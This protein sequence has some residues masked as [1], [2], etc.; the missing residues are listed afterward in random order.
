MTFS[1]DANLVFLGD[2]YTTDLVDARHSIGQWPFIFNLEAPIS[3]RGRPAPG[4]V[5]L[6]MEVDYILDCF[7]RRPLAVCLANNHIMDYGAEAFEDTLGLLSGRGIPFFGAGH[8]QDNFNNPAFVEVGDQ[9]VAL[10]GYVCPSTHPIYADQTHPGVCPI[11][12]DHIRNDMRKAKTE[13]ATRI[14]V[15]LHWGA[16]EV[17]L[18]KPEDVQIAHTLIDC[19]ADVI[20]GHHAHVPQL[21]EDFSSK[22][23]AYGLGNFAMPDVMRVLAYADGD[24]N[25]AHIRVKKQ[26]TRNRVSLGLLWNVKDQY[27]EIV[28]FECAGK[29]VK[30]R[31]PSWPFS[32]NVDVSAK[33]YPLR[34]E[35]H[36]RKRKLICV[37]ENFVGARMLPRPRH[38]ASLLRILAKPS[39][40]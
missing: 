5:N 9:K 4:K 7:G 3:K 24:G 23:I 25:F 32:R 12:L 11:D 16:Q 31:T 36:L 13:G 15:S 35:I 30:K 6:C 2:W 19:G 27:W 39:R 1:I 26:K 18:P 20:I 34:F 37:A 22:P 40:S 28:E 8:V 17:F 29:M 21:V 10:M 14:V 38:F 33:H